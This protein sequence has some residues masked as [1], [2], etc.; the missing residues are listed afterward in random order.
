MN[1]PRI[2]PLSDP[3]PAPVAERLAKLLPPGMAAPQLFLTVARN[4]GLF[5]W[6]VDSG[7][8]GPSGL[9]DRRTL[10]PALRE[11]LILR[12]CVAARNDYEFNLH[13]QTISQRMGLSEAQIDDLRRGAPSETLWSA[14]ERAAM[15]LV[16]TLVQRL[17]VDDT[18]YEAARAHFDEPALVEMTH[19]VGLYT[20]VAMLVA[21]ARPAF[22]RYRPGPPFT[23]TP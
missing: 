10:A 13:V 11:L 20:G 3:L 18:T 5:G 8:L 15:R 9:A 7:L 19:L 21:L 16:D 17:A 6:L 2:R 14:A 12:T 1:A 23:T 4:A 22:D